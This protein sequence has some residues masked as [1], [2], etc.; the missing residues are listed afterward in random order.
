M[1]RFCYLLNEITPGGIQTEEKISDVQVAKEK[2]TTISVRTSRIN[3]LLGQKFSG[4]D[5]ANLL[6]RLGSKLSRQMMLMSSL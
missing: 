4:E 3:L 2:Q 1:E 6:I 5:V